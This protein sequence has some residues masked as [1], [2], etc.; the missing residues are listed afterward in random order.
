MLVLQARFAWWRAGTV[1]ASADGTTLTLAPYGAQPITVRGVGVASPRPAALVNG[2]G[3]CDHSNSSQACI[4]FALQPG[5]P[6]T[7][8]SAANAT[9]ASSK[10]LVAAKRDALF[11]SYSAYGDY[12]WAAEAVGAAVGWNFVFGPSERGPHLP[13][14][15][16]WA[17]GKIPV[18]E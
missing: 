13:V 2:L 5:Q 17:G 9:S 14:S 6:V 15:P 8:S 7:F 3:Y 16:G 11:K 4:A 12:A 18:Y 10:T 1:S